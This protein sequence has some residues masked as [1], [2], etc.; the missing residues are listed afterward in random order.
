MAFDG[1]VLKNVIYELNNTIINGKI[2]K[3]FEPNK[4]EIILSIYSGGINYSLDIV[5]SSNNYRMNLST[6]TKPNPLVAPSFCMLLRK[7]LIGS[8]IK[9]IYTTDLERVVTI[10]LECYNELNDLIHKKLIVE[11]MGKHSNIILVNENDRIIDSLRHLDSFAH[12]SRDILPAREYIYPEITKLSFMDCN[13]N[14]FYELVSK[15]NSLNSISNIFNGFSKSCVDT[16]IRILDINDC[17]ETSLNKIYNYFNDVLDFPN[18]KC[19]YINNKKDYSIIPTKYISN[20]EEYVNFSDNTQTNFF[21]DDFYTYKENLDKFISYRSNLLKIVLNASKKITK[22]LNNINLKLQECNNMDTYKL[23]GELLTTYLY[24][25]P[26]ENVE[27][28]ELENYYDNNNLISIPLD[29]KLSPSGNAKLYFKKYNK[30]KKALEIVS[31]QKKETEKEIE[32]LETIVY[33]LDASTSLSDLE[34]INNEI[35]ENILF[36]DLAHSKANIM[37]SKKSNNRVN[38]KLLDSKYHLGEPIIYTVN[39]YTVYVGKNNKQNDY[40]TTKLAKH[41]DYWFHTQDIHG[42]HVIL[43]TNGDDIDIDTINIVASIAAKHSKAAN[44]SNVPV[45]Y[46]LVKYVKKPSGAKPGKVIYTNYKTANVQ[47]CK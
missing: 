6:N 35:S 15:E 26:S 9:K 13:F 31:L 11:L 22:K 2:N 29:K 3:I 46:T 18:S 30:L 8:K 23:Y 10:E 41:H 16:A 36:K 47:P 21:L 43:Q 17:T 14:K 7:H 44:S 40:I 28:V 19:V 33:E 25:L 5:I 24:K 4:N 12:S 42:S 45:D 39:G 37:Q 27:K 32:Y 20:I 1:I 38:K 34:D